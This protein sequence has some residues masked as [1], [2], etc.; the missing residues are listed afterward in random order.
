[1]GGFHI[2][3]DESPEPF[4]EVHG[5]RPWSTSRNFQRFRSSAPLVDQ[6]IVKDFGELPPVASSQGID[7]LLMLAHGL[8][9]AIAFYRVGAVAQASHPRDQPMII[10]LE[11][12]ISRCRDD[13]LVDELVEPE[14]FGQL[15]AHVI[16][17]ALEQ[18]TGIPVYDSI[19]TTV[20]KSLAVAG[21]DPAR[22]EGWG[23]LFREPTAAQ[24]PDLTSTACS[25]LMDACGR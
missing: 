25:S 5:T 19:A 22:L 3:R 2:S 18:E 24:T 8:A 6:V 10:C 17:A 4:D 7:H 23:S 9:P 14:V 13:P 16:V 21:L 20:W 11:R 12:A 1:V 15:P